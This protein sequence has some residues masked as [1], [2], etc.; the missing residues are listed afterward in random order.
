[1]DRAEWRSRNGHHSHHHCPTLPMR[2]IGRPIINGQSA[3][4][5]TT[6]HR[7]SA[8]SVCLPFV[9]WFP[10][11][12]N[13][14]VQQLAPRTQQSYSA[15]VATVRLLP[16]LQRSKQYQW[17]RL[18]TTGRKIVAVSEVTTRH[19][20]SAASTA[21][22]IAAVGEQSLLHWHSADIGPQSMD[23][24]S[25][26]MAIQSGNQHSLVNGTIQ[27]AANSRT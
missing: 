22:F 8:I 1:L 15:M 17:S 4:G 25:E 20:H 13:P 11:V 24:Q 9:Q 26:P 5:G 19:G 3:I 27:P 14:M 23:Q 6:G 21:A 12:C 18:H 7:N 10:M 2:T 16:S